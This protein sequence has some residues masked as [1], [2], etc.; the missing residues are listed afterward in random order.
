MKRKT[1]R[2][3]LVIF[4]FT[5]VVMILLAT[6]VFLVS[7][8]KLHA[9]SNTSLKDYADSANTHT[10]ITKANR[11]LIYDRS[12]SIIAQDNRTYNIYCILDSSRPSV[13]GSISYVKDPKYTAQVLSTILNTKIKQQIGI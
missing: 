4:V 2:M 1:N 8:V 10:E 3:L 9:R 7:V 5:L 12:G 6:N 13:K 11:G